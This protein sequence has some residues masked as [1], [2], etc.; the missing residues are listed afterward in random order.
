V[1]SGQLTTARLG[2][3]RFSNQ[4][5]KEIADSERSTDSERSK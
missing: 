2:Q 5:V 3:N 4:D 1:L